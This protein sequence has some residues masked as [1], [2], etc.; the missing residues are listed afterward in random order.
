MKPA[1]VTLP[2]DTEVCVRRSFEAPVDLLWRAYTDAELFQRWCLGPPGWTMP[3]CEMDVRVGGTFRWRW[4]SD[5]DGKEFGFHGEYREVECHAKIV[6]TEVY[7]PGDMGVSMG[8]EPTVVTVTFDEQD[9]TTTMTTVVR[10]ASQA[11]RDAALASG[12]TDG[13]EMTYERL[14]VLLAPDAP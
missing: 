8:D 5:E 3:V 6:N 10:Y 4:R 9:G 12:M 2:S 11:D 13:M 7:D 1:D 14:D